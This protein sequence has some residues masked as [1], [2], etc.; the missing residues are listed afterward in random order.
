MYTGPNGCKFDRMTDGPRMI[1]LSIAELRAVAGYAAACAR[2]VLAIFEGGRPDDRRPRTAIEAAEA[3][4][5]GAERT[6]SMRNCAWAAQQAAHDARDAGHAA[7]SEVARLPRCGRRGVPPSHPESD[8]GQTHTRVSWSR[9]TSGR[10][11]H[12]QFYKCRHRS[13]RAVTCSCATD[14]DQRPPALPT[15]PFGRW[16]G[17]RI[18]APVGRIA[19]AQLMTMVGFSSGLRWAAP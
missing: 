1:E 16:A 19:P 14:R 5:N 10:T 4:A 18:D 12:R 2:P 9:R 3:F 11:L 13:D 7:A 17:G 15:S 6:K 8:A